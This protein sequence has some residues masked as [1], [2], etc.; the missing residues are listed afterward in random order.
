MQLEALSVPRTK[1]ARAIQHRLGAVLRHARRA[2]IP[3]EYEHAHRPVARPDIEDG[4]SRVAR[5][6]EEIADQLKLLGSALVLGLLT[7][8]PLV[9]VRLRGPI[10]VVARPPAASCAASLTHPH[11][12]ALREPPR[13]NVRQ[14]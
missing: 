5:E 4:D 7:A 3:V 9:D 1:M 12:R 10:V 14:P 2:R 13:P 8:H 11:G 6:G